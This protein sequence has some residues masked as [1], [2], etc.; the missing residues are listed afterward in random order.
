MPGIRL[1]VMAAKDTQMI[2][3]IKKN[4]AI[5][6]INSF[7]EFFMQIV[8][9]Y[10]KEY[11][12][13]LRLIR[14]ERNYLIEELKKLNLE[15]YPSQANYIMCCLNNMSSK[16]LAISLLEEQNL[17]IK[18]LSEKEGFGGKDFIRIA[19]RNRE[20]NQKLIEGLRQYL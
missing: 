12:E 16:Q 15:V 1:G 3:Y 5:W 14:E 11:R 20:D 6:N 19:V 18:D 10:E 2:A 17:L 8:E 4:L 7:G 13:S 9:K